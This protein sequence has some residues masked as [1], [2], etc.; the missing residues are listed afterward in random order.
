M[1]ST[2]TPGGIELIGAG[3]QSGT[4][5]T[6]TNTNLQILDRMISQ[7]GAITLSGTTHTLTISDG[8]LSD[9]QYGVLV[10]GGS[11]SGT[12]TVTISP[13]DAQR[14][15]IV[16]NDS[17][18]S[19]VLTQG[20][21]GNVTVADGKTALVY[22][23]G[24]GS[25]AAVVDLT[26]DLAVTALTLADFGVTASASELN[27]L[28][29]ITATTAELNIL[30]GVTSTTAEL[31]IL[32]GVTW[33]LSDYNTLT[34]TA[35]ELNILDGVTATTS[36]INLLD[37]ASLVVSNVTATAAE[38]NVLDGIT[39]IASQVE[40]EAGTATDKLMTPE[41]TKQAVE[42]LNPDWQ[43][44]SSGTSTSAIVTTIPHGLGG[45]P[46]RVSVVLKCVSSD[47]G[48]SVGEEVHFMNTLFTAGSRP[49]NF[50]VMFSADATN[51][52]IRRGDSGIRVIGTDGRNSNINLS[53]Y[54]YVARASL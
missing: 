17:G 5:N 35:T 11:P 3:E 39:G 37:G 6:T 10:F 12:N 1:P 15:Y 36:E 19:V 20:S 44:T 8:T 34:A 53:N 42:A 51:I 38:L 50:G 41:R 18:E 32:D 25:G 24:A 9:G 33:T 27:T 47:N 52:Y 22:C 48:F 40:A 45:T 28:D 43:F 2:Y 29:G 30:D 14:S 49:E 31:N 23:D 16:K 21:G 7:A 46:S 26:A 4:W 54:E 13:N